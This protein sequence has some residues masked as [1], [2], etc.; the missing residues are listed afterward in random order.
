MIK[1]A[2][3][4]LLLLVS[5]FCGI[6]YEILYTKLLGNLLG[7]Q[8]TINATVLLTFLGGIGF[9]T[10]YAHRFIKYLWLIEAGIGLYAI[11]L[12]LLYSSIDNL[13]YSQI[14]SLGTNVFA[15]ACVAF[16]ILAIPSFLV[17]CSLPLFAAYLGES[18]R[19][20]VFATTYSIYNLGAVLTALVLEF[21]ILRSF[22][23]SVTM[24]SLALLNFAVAGSLLALTR[25]TQLSPALAPSRTIFSRQL[26]IS[27]FV[28]SIASAIFQ[29]LSIKLFEFVF[30]PFNET[31]A[32]VLAVVLSGIAVG[33][34]ATGW[35]KLN[36]KSTL[37]LALLGMTLFLLLFRPV[38]TLYAALYPVVVEDYYQ[39]VTLKLAIVF[40]LM[41]I[42]AVGFG[43]TVPALLNTHKDV[44]RDS[45]FLLFTSS[46]GNVLGFVLM[47]FFLHQYFEYGSLIVCIGVLIVVALFV[48]Q[49]LKSFLTPIA[50]VLLFVG[51]YSSQNTWE[52]NLLYISHKNFRSVALRDK[53]VRNL[54]KIEKFKGAQDV[55]AIVSQN[56]DP[57][58]FINGYTS[59]PLESANE[60]I[61][62][63]ISTMLAPDT[64][65]ALVLGVGSGATAG[66]V[67]L[68]FDE[69]EAVEINK[70][71]LDHLDLMKKYNFNITQRDNV[72][73]IHDDGIRFMKNAKKQYSLILNTV[74]S[75]QFFSSSK[76][77]TR[78]FFEIVKK[79]L[80]PDGVYAT[81][82]DGKIGAKGMNVVLKSLDSVFEHCALSYIRSNYFLLVCSKQPVS[83]RNYQHVVD[84]GV[85]EDYF[86]SEGDFPIEFLPYLVLSTQVLNLPAGFKAPLNTMDFPVLEHLMAGLPTGSMASFRSLVLNPGNF[87][88]L[89]ARM[90]ESIDW[91]PGEFYYFAEHRL[92]SRASGG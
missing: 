23:L 69:T 56:D 22:G 32:L 84:N 33:S 1:H 76:L 42:P 17:G 24:Q 59:I 21:I 9:G 8:F 88:A 62:G 49:G 26:L 72:K 54:T 31:F 79:K 4:P 68:L 55:F 73:L 65:R 14:P 51:Y 35:L 89:V 2:T 64:Q 6:S 15:S 19:E 28:V 91:R 50:A 82:A 46:M 48:S 34:T 71:V 77:Y 25:L 16:V 47:T 7:N 37:M 61:V 27:L 80:T 10:L 52:E 87:S 92:S 45:G 5:G 67:G 38:T 18:Q 90:Q 74:T 75:P 66:T 20:H 43:A 57:Y 70:V 39:L 44:A 3:I 81:W 58:F 63:A 11:V 30:G 29:L 53:A 41:F 86:A 83:V 36:Y 78:D 85:L 12:T 60:K 40:L 13:V